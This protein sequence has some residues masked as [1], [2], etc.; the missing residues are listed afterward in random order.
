MA[1]TAS[2]FS[3]FFTSTTALRAFFLKIPNIVTFLLA[4]EPALRNDQPTE[5]VTLTIPYGSPLKGSVV[6]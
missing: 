3:I 1:S 5:T 2:R 4:G 6:K